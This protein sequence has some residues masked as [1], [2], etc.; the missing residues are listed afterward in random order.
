MG[1]SYAITQYKIN[2]ISI[3]SVVNSFVYCKL[4]PSLCNIHMMT[5]LVS[6]V[7]IGLSEHIHVLLLHIRWH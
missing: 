5:L 7:F 2:W 4:V 1:I 3:Q 6:Q